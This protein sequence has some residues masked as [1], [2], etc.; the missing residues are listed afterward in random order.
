M[1]LPD[2]MFRQ[3]LLQYLT[4]VD[5]VKLDNVCMN[6]KYRS[7]LLS[8]LQGLILIKCCDKFTLTQVLKYKWLL[9]RRIYLVSMRII[10][11]N[12]NTSM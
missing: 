2:D 9:L 5:I 4:V 1:K 8:K 3:E 6:H 10:F 11:D 7:Q 12:L